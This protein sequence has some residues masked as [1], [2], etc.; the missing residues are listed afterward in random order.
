MK[1]NNVIKKIIY[2]ISCNYKL[3]LLLLC[4]LDKKYDNIIKLKNQI[5]INE[6]R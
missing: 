1:I 2:A 6:M 4:E 5:D 3:K